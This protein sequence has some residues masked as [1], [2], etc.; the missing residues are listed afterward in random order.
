MTSPL[1]TPKRLSRGELHRGRITATE[2]F[3]K[4]T[5]KNRRQLMLVTRVFGI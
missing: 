1:V 2:Q 4:E 3:A 5:K